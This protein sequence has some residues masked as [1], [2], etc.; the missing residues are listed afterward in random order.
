MSRNKIT[1]LLLIVAA[2][3]LAHAGRA[4]ASTL[5]LSCDGF[6]YCHIVYTAAAGETNIVRVPSDFSFADIKDSG[7]TITVGAGCHLL[8]D[9][10]N[11]YCDLPTF[12]NQYFLTGA[13]VDLGDG[14][15]I[16]TAPGDLNLVS[17]QGGP[18]NDAIT[19]SGR[20]DNISGGADTDTL[21]GG[22]GDDTIAGGDGD[23]ILN[24]GAGEG[25]FVGSLD[26][27][28]GQDHITGSST[29]DSIVG[30]PGPD[31]ID[32]GDGDD[33][34]LNPAGSAADVYDGGDGFDTVDYTGDWAFLGPGPIFIL[35]GVNVTLDGVANDG[36][37]LHDTLNAD[38]VGT[39][40]DN[41]QP[42]VEKV[43]GTLGPDRM[44]ATQCGGGAC[45][46]VR[47]AFFYGAEA[48]DV[49]QGN[50]DGGVLDGGAGN[51]FLTA[52]TGNDQLSGGDND[53]SL[54]A[55]A[56]NDKLD[57]GNGNDTLWPDTG[58]DT[59][60]G[61]AG[62]DSLGGGDGDDKLVE[63]GTNL[64]LTNTALSGLGSDT[65]SG[66]ESAKLSGGAGADT[67]DAS[68]FGGPVRLEGYEGADTLIGG[69]F[70]DVLV[71]SSPG[72]D[73]NCGPGGGGNTMTGG[74]GDDLMVGSSCDAPET[75]IC[76]TPALDT[77]IETGNVDFTASGNAQS[78]TLVGVG[79]DTL[80]CVRRVHLV[81]GASANTFDTSAYTGVALLD[82]GGAND[83]LK[84]GTGADVLNGEAGDDVLT[85]GTGND[86]LTGGDGTDQVAETADV[87]LTLTDTTLTGVGSDT[88]A[89][90]ERAK[91][92]GGNATNTLTATSFTGSAELNGAG[93]AD[94]LLGGSGN[95]KLTGGA[96]IDSFDAGGGDDTIETRDSENESSIACGAGTGD[97]ARVDL[98][99]VAAGDCETILPPDITPP[100][101]PGGLQQTG[102]TGTTVSISWAAATDDQGTVGYDLYL[103]GTKIDDTSGLTY[104][105]TGLHC[106]MTGTAG[107][108]AFDGAPNHSS[109]ST[110]SV[111]TAACPT[112]MGLTGP[113]GL[114]KSRNAS[115]S[116]T[117]SASAHHFKCRLDAEP[118]ALC[119]SPKAYASLPE[120]GHTF[121]VFA[122]D[123]DNDPGPVTSRT[124]T[125]DATRPNTTITRGPASRTRSHTARFGFSSSEPGSHFQCKLD[126]RPWRACSS[127]KTLRSVATG[128]HIFRV[129]AI[130][131]AGNID[132]SV[133]T[134][135]W[136]IL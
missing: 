87:N 133:A 56:G 34:M 51:D 109:R 43:I 10:H 8:G 85:G 22:G 129:R 131:T 83:T 130:D 119:P 40:L 20:G 38:G 127:S 90:I 14:N 36:N 57:G 1:V 32:A 44:T 7:A 25:L 55:G 97:F 12:P 99:D 114:V 88:L 63:V 84:G 82:G 17:A 69:A 76:P 27:G 123:S 72:G 113:K 98:A 26:G 39:L 2:A 136:Q 6:E 117:G 24:G 124:W 54:A 52:G 28:A 79:N 126:S 116:F 89:T 80:R 135:R 61:G 100:S 74:A 134:R 62:N 58:N 48:S 11:A 19:G 78:A 118:F 42:T 47:P 121:Q 101:A 77:V 128:R 107:V 18:G 23:D 49:L 31:T 104:T 102:S 73:F 115:F 41:V 67:I 110:L 106:D 46:P 92:T 132:S 29:R 35:Q 111:A 71:S 75:P 9:A 66:I 86:T 68:A 16:L 103:N 59:L 105:F 96:G 15:D 21:L 53:D 65:L 120:G 5:S 125:I 37:A 30:G 122:E 33:V 112:I 81:G 108:E 70:N 93:G 64:T 94:T 95:D 45:N 60:T 13:E 4:Q 3:L 91:L 50:N